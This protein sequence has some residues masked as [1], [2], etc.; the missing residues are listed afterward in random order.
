MYKLTNLT[1]AMLMMLLLAACGNDDET[2]PITSSDDLEDT[3]TVI[4]FSADV[5]SVS[6]IQG[7]T[8]T[9]DVDI[10]GSNMAYDLTLDGSQFTT[11]GNYE[12][13]LTST[14]NGMTQT[15]TDSYSNVMG[16]G[17][18]TNDESTIT[19]NGSFFDL[20]WN[21]IDLSATQGEQTA[22]YTINADDQLVISQNEIM[23]T[24]S[25][26]IMMT[27]TFVSSSVWER[28]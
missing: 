2:P 16:T 28:K 14:V 13:T 25:N 19:I 9:S 1:L 24:N 17:N 26:G 7:Q 21:G 12:M 18:Y 11:D 8:I 3:W 23:T 6:E 20:E 4:S 15:N 27:T 5:E 22:D 10:V